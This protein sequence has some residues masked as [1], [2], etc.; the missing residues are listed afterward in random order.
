MEGLGG[1]FASIRPINL[2]ESRM[3]GSWVLRSSWGAELDGLTLRAMGSPHMDLQLTTAVTQLE[4]LGRVR[5]NFCL[6]GGCSAES[7]YE[8]DTAFD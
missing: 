1:E 3:N 5:Q 7:T 8:S 4:S 6:V 2:A